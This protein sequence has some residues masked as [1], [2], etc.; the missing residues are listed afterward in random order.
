MV[1][2]RIVAIDVTNPAAMKEIG[3]FDLPGDLSDSR[4]V[5]D[6]IYVVTYENGNCW[7]CVSNQPRTTVTSIA[8]GDPASIRK[9]EQLTFADQRGAS[10]WYRRS[11]H[12]TTDRLYVSGMVYTGTWGPDTGH[13]TIQV[14]DI[15]DPAGRLVSGAQVPVNGQIE[16]RW[17]MDELSGVL[18]VVSQS[19][20]TWANGPP[21]VVETFTVKSAQN[22][23]PLG[24]LTLT[25]PK[26][27]N[28]KSVRFDGSRAYAVTFEQ[29][30][31]LFTIDLADPAA[32]KQVGE[33]EMPGFLHHMEP[34]GDRLVALG[35]DSGN[36]SGGLTVSI[37]DVADLA[38]PTLLSRA[39]FGSQWG[40]LPEDQDRIHKAF[41]LFDQNELIVMPFSG[42]SYANAGPAGCGSYVSGV[43]LFDFT[44][45]Q[46]TARGIVPLRGNARRAFLHK[47][48]LFAVSDD[49]VASFDIDD[50]DA[51]ARRGK[52]ALGNVAD[53]TVRFGD[54]LVELGSDWW[55]SE[56]QITVVPIAGGAQGLAVATIELAKAVNTNNDPCY[57]RYW[58]SFAG[59][60]QLFVAG[61]S[62][63]IAYDAGFAGTSGRGRMGFAV[64]DMTDPEHPAL[65]GSAVL[66]IVKS[67]P[68][69]YY[70]YGY[71]GCGVGYYTNPTGVW[72]SGDRIAQVGT[73]IVVQELEP[74]ELSDA[75]NS[76][77]TVR[78]TKAI[79]HAV[80]LSDPT[81]I[82]LAST[83]TIQDGPS[84]SGI[85][86]AGSH[87]FT[88]HQ[89]NLMDQPGRTRFFVDRLD[90]AK[91]SSPARTKINVPGSL[92]G[93]D[94]GGERV[95]TVD[96]RRTV[97]PLEVDAQTSWG[98]CG[99][100]GGFAQTGWIYGSNTFGRP[101]ACLRVYRTL[102]LVAL[103][104]GGATLLDS[105]EPTGD[106]VAKVEMG[107]DRVWIQRSKYVPAAPGYN[108]MSVDTLTGIR[109]GH[110]ELASRLLRRGDTFISDRNG[111]RFVI[112]SWN[113]TSRLTVFDTADAA[114]PRQVL[115]HEESRV[116]SYYG[117]TSG[118]TLDSHYL[119]LSMGK[120]GAS[121][122][123]LE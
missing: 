23:A 89:E 91:A 52:L 36:T 5:G 82:H 2:S 47:D 45:D 88:S 120:Y 100:E 116:R 4:M 15:S 7:G 3:V 16:S 28:L 12:V 50:R 33:V 115:E 104:A 105:F 71:Y 80:D 78:P 44:R 62:V 95:M 69:Q 92:L 121:A 112:Q 113:D 99:V 43:Q 26:R 86:V 111:S 22:I 76:P 61:S 1:S 35:V 41:R 8:A 81:N 56:P 110:L 55:T 31:P 20:S 17:Q 67:A 30:D 27:E 93:V 53:K 11:I 114:N 54:H 60:S 39:N 70:A 24:K 48:T 107:A 72:S 19:G 119:I 101:E 14:V 90:L 6:I 58:S 38:Q 85:F 66:E 29:K 122:I 77:Y 40:G 18:R 96:Y 63:Y 87:V 106:L 34:R 84:A 97:T 42:W 13:S 21:P 37:F 9:I 109:A 59:N 32:P 108:E 94:F 103:G 25:L 102:K 74:V 64:I 117:S 65:R 51:P 57:G 49:Q 98:T 75:G 79:L 123:P 46:V 118:I 83:T 68:P 10:G 73:T